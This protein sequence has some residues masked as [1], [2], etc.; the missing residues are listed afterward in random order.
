[1]YPARPESISLLVEV[2]KRKVLKFES[3]GSWEI[4]APTMDGPPVHL[5]QSAIGLSLSLRCVPLAF[6][7][8]PKVLHSAELPALRI[9]LPRKTYYPGECVTGYLVF[10][11]RI[12]PKIITYLKLKTVCTYSVKFLHKTKSSSSQHN[13]SREVYEWRTYEKVKETKLLLKEVHVEP[14]QTV[15]RFSIWL[16]PSA[17]PSVF[18]SKGMG[19][20]FGVSWC[21]KAQLRVKGDVTMSHF[22]APLNV[23]LYEPREYS[24]QQMRLGKIKLGKPDSLAVDARY[25]FV[26]GAVPLSS[27]ESLKLQLQIDNLESKPFD[28]MEIQLNAIIF[29]QYGDER[30]RSSTKIFQTRAPVVQVRRLEFKEIDFPRNSRFSFSRTAKVVY[31]CGPRVGATIAQLSNHCRI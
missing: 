7:G 2:G 19:A 30:S 10:N 27:S 15:W 17:D 4:H 12:N 1:M 23:V 29:A 9:A 24:A 26:G 6:P 13:G 25:Q 21:I 16:S 18:V 3:L 31:Q 28:K 8:I 20:G 22:T 5:T 14:G 11:V